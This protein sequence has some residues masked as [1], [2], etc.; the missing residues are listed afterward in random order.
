MAAERSLKPH[1]LADGE[2]HVWYARADLIGDA[3]LAQ[4]ESLLSRDEIARRNR[5]RFEKDRRLLLV[6]HALLRLGLSR[7]VDV[8]P[9]GWTF[10]QNG[11]GKPEIARPRTDPPLRFNLSHTRGMA[12]LAV[13]LGREIGVDV[14]NCLRNI[15]AV[16]LA[17]RYFS[18]REAAELRSLPPEQRQSRFFDFWTLK[19]AYIKARG[20]GLS[21]PLRDFSMA[22]DTS[23]VEIKFA[24]GVDDVAVEWQFEQF[25]PSEHHKIAVAVRRD[26][27]TH[28]DIVCRET[29]TGTAEP[30]SARRS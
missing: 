27:G 10:V 29:A 23:P 16:G 22:V 19:E 13:T 12:A 1:S 14:E 3:A 28:L 21:F 25:H 6:S 2:V 5:Y 20:M 24:A 4:Y 30:R 26:T 17:G 7:Y 8:A 11:Y 9:T 15:D 18:P